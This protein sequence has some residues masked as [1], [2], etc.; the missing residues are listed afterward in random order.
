MTTL[1]A[2]AGLIGGL[3][4]GLF[5]QQVAGYTPIQAGLATTPVS[6]ILFFLS[7]TLGKLASGT[8]PGCR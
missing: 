4:V 2:Y 8:G 3:L 7:P 5:L 1:A 6:L